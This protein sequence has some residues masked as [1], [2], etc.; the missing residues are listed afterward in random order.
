[1]CSYKLVTVKFEVWGLQS[2]VEQFVHKVGIL[3]FLCDFYF[4]CLEQVVDPQTYPFLTQ[5]N[6]LTR[7]DWCHCQRRFIS[8]SE[9]TQPV[10]QTNQI[11]CY[12][13]PQIALHHFPLPWLHILNIISPICQI[14]FASPLQHLSLG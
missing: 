3:K 13:L 2:R 12:H 8:C 1:M 9:S 4:L 10:G 6:F 5:S 7:A 11:R 14:H